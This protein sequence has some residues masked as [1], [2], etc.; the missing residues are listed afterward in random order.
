M[1]LSQTKGKYVQWSHKAA[2]KVLKKKF[3]WGNYLLILFWKSCLRLFYCWWMVVLN[4][5]VI[6]LTLHL[7]VLLNVVEL[8]FNKFQIVRSFTVTLTKK[9]N[10]FLMKKDGKL[11]SDSKFRT[12]WC[13][14]FLVGKT[15]MVLKNWKIFYSSKLFVASLT[16]PV[17][18]ILQ[19]C[20]IGYCYYCLNYC[21]SYIFSDY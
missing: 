21:K 13:L 1:G 7:T 17:L 15:V 18:L 10:Q 20:S 5:L 8:C 16:F 2:Y 12:C 11:D 19:K 3:F 4:L 6:I 9:L 14:K